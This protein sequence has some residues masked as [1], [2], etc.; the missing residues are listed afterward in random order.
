MITEFLNSASVIIS[1]KNLFSKTID[2]IIEQ[3]FMNFNL[4]RFLNDNK[5]IL[6]LYNTC[7]DSF[8]GETVEISTH[9]KKYAAYVNFIYYEF[10]VIFSS[11][12]RA[13]LDT[14]IETLKELPF[15][16]STLD[17]ISLI[18]DTRDFEQRLLIFICLNVKAN[19]HL[20]PDNIIF[21]MSV[22]NILSGVHKFFVMVLNIGYSLCPTEDSTEFLLA[23]Y[24]IKLLSDACN[25]EVRPTYVF[26]EAMRK[27]IFYEGRFP[28]RLLG[29]FDHIFYDTISLIGD[30][31]SLFHKDEL[32]SLFRYFDSKKFLYIRIILNV[33]CEFKDQ[34]DNILIKGI[35][36]NEMD[37]MNLLKSKWFY[38]FL[39]GCSH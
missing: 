5:D 27:F 9:H 24:P 3:Q 20:Y 6:K 23:G 37:L 1:E 29:S 18:D 17:H 32:H 19:I 31:N 25:L 15:V 34:N 38:L 13:L 16:D 11:E 30:E 22:N 4:D 8:I 26:A 35:I 14:I 12:S 2:D 36:N 7:I 10:I 39:Y 21:P 33:L 28:D